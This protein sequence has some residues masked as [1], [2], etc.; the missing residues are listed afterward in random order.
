MG[1]VVFPDAQWKVFLTASAQERAGRRYKQ[2]KQKGLQVK[3]SDLLN[4]I[5]ARDRRDAARAVAPLKAA[6]DAVLV[7]STGVPIEQ[8]V[9]RVLSVVR[10]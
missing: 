10:A 9:E 7:D 8:V 3:L 2:L 4:E 5:E 1:T 6:P